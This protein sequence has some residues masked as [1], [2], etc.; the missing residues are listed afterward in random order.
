M[1]IYNFL[2]ILICIGI[3]VSSYTQVMD[4]QWGQAQKN[5]FMWDLYENHDIVK[6]SN[7]EDSINL[8]G[9]VYFSNGGD[10]II[11]EFINPQGTTNKVLQIGGMSNDVLSAMDINEE[12]SLFVMGSFFDS[13]DISLNQETHWATATDSITRFIA[14]YDDGLNLKWAATISAADGLFH[15][16]SLLGLEDGSVIVSGAYMDSVKLITEEEVYEHI[17]PGH[18]TYCIKINNEGQMEWWNVDDLISEEFGFKRN[19]SYKNSHLIVSN[20]SL[21]RS[22]LARLDINSGEVIWQHVLEIKVN[23]HI[24]DN[25]GNTFFTGN[26]DEFSITD[27]DPG[28][29]T[30]YLDPNVID[31]FLLKLDSNGNLQW[32]KNII[33]GDDIDTGIALTLSKDNEMMIT[34]CIQSDADFDPSDNEF[35][36]NA[37]GFEDV[38]L[39]SYNIDGD[40]LW[41]KTLGGSSNDVGFKIQTIQDT[42]LLYG[43]FYGEV[44]FDLNNESYILESANDGMGISYFLAKY[45]NCPID[46][47][48]SADQ[49]ISPEESILIYPNPS[50]SYFTINRL[51][52][53]V[54]ISDIHGR[55]LYFKDE[56]S[57]L[58]KI[59]I[60]NLSVGTYVL[61]GQTS[62]GSY[63]KK[64]LKK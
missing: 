20:S 58:E 12:N 19:L 34:G 64:I 1:K 42:V 32:A 23:N 51:M 25:D 5:S 39:A 55:L 22:S 30:V 11:L 27:F 45:T 16:E 62:Q 61:N 63:S 18:H 8:G 59:D 3:P 28:P 49:N 26:F 47:C 43:L 29:D 37:S 10:D 35:I 6:L 4:I 21:D 54:S 31:V 46:G 38:F 14:N 60:S 41:A 36:L 56:I 40:F 2:T 17:S 50:Q 13:L 33:T 52:Y 9:D 57:S 53:N 7:F 24:S 15:V 48:V 44:N